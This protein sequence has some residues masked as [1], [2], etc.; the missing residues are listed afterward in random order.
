M[1]QKEKLTVET[2]MSKEERL[3]LKQTNFKRLA[4]ARTKTAVKKLNHLSQLG[5]KNSYAYTDEQLDKIFAA[6]D[7]AVRDMKQKF[8]AAGQEKDFVIDL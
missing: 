8:S 5:N 3:K 7:N 4:T 6:V 2:K 1:D